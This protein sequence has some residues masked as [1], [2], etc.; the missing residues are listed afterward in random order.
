MRLLLAADRF[1]FGKC[2]PTICSLMRIAYAVL[3]FVLVGMW[4][5]DGTLWFTDQGALQDGMHGG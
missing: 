2:D 1:L 3:L 4:L 5:L